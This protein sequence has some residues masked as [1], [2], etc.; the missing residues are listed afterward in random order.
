MNTFLIIVACAT[1][2]S[3]PLS[4]TL[5][6][7]VSAASEQHCYSMVRDKM[8]AMHLKPSLFKVKCVQQ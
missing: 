4:N 2:V 5:T 1:T 6:V 8:Q 7:Q 3:C